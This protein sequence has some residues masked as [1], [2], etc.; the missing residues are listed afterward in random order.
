MKRWMIIIGILCLVG[1]GAVAGRTMFPIV[2]K[3]PPPLPP[4]VIIETV[5]KEIEVEGPERVVERVKWRTK[6]VIVEKEVVKEIIKF[7]EA[8]SVESGEEVNIYGRI[9]IEADKYEGACAAGVCF[10]W[11]GQADCQIRSGEQEEWVTLISEPF[12]LDDSRAETTIAPVEEYTFRWRV[13]MRGGISEE[14]EWNVGATYYPWKRLGVFANYQ[15]LDRDST[16][17]LPQFETTVSIEQE[18]GLFQGGLAVT[19]GGLR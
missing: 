14:G 5:V 7:I 8:D 1:L 10:G 19:F 11:K 4:E 15:S 17:F 12:S 13:E 16:L 6:E 3:P 2:I 18:S 9:T